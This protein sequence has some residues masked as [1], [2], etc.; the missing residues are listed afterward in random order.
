MASA[1]PHANNL[2]LAPDR[3]PHQHFHSIF[4]DRMLFLTPNQRCQGTEDNIGKRH[5]YSHIKYSYNR[6]FSRI[7]L[8]RYLHNSAVTYLQA[9]KAVETYQN[10]RDI[11]KIQAVL[12]WISEHVHNTTDRQLQWMS[13]IYR[14]N[15][16]FSDHSTAG[17]AHCTTS[18]RQL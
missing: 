1:G 12:Q 7:K 6:R 5:W 9:Y 14:Y 8:Y 13:E 17:I 11:L 16:S 3:Q 4:T 15:L 10:Q 18:C 2:H